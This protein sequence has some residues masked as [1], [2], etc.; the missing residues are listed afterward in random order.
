M[1]AISPTLRSKTKAY[2]GSCI[3]FDSFI[4]MSFIDYDA[5]AK[6]VLIF[7]QNLKE[8]NKKGKGVGW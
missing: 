3:P 5:P 4:A 7:K 6:F 2:Q 8:E 1:Y